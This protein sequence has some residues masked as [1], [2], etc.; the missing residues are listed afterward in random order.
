MDTLPKHLR[1]FLL[2]VGFALLDFLVFCVVF[3]IS[4]FV[5]LSLFIL[6][7]CCPSS[8][9]DFWH[10]QTFLLSAICILKLAHYNKTNMIVILRK[11]YLQ[12]VP[13][14]HKCNNMN[15]NKIHHSTCTQF[16]RL[17]SSSFEHSLH[18]YWVQHC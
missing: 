7:L 12:N 18:F 17:V 6:L 9:Y 11:Y 15:Q 1:S 3:C 5:L 2:I 14:F 4:L 16:S 10:I 8:S 13:I